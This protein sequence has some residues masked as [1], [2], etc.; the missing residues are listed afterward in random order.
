[1]LEQI[2]QKRGELSRTEQKVAEWILRHP[3]Q[4]AG[5]TL[6]EVAEA[7]GAS[8]PTVVR[9]CRHVGLGGFRE[10]TLRL[11]EALSRPASY[12]HAGVTADDS[13]GDAVAKV[14]DSSIQALL[15]VRSEL[16]SMPLDRAVAAM[17]GARQLVFAG[18]G[19]SG[20]VASDA[21]HKFFRLGIPASVFT[22]APGLI[23]FAAIAGPGDV[24]VI[25]SYTGDWP[26]VIDT[27][28]LARD[29]G[30]TVI[31][32]TDPA[33]PLATG[34]DILVPCRVLEDTSIYTPMSARLAQLALFDALHTAVALELGADAV[35]RLRG[36]KRA[37]A[38]I[39]ANLNRNQ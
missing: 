30:A 11:T 23:Q 16:G 12:V 13:L 37:L 20:H 21:R 35:E 24:L 4:A 2:E 17:A 10:L 38:G 34:V 33:A 31:A 15:D 8:E 22:D 1:M 39:K 7:T 9:F 36:A 25:V 14:L 3:R 26:E 6:R 27:A 19:A 5:A 28:T 18:L 29:N 32:I